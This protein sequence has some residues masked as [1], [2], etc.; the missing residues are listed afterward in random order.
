LI[1]RDAAAYHGYGELD[2]GAVFEAGEVEGG[3]GAEVVVVGGAR[4]AAGG[5]VEVAELLAAEGGAAAAVAG[6]VD[7]AADVAFW[8]DGF[9]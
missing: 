5:V 4:A 6:G 3:V 7:V 2:R 9:H 8:C 1:E